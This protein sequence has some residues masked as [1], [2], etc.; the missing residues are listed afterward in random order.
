MGRQAATDWSRID[1]SLPTRVIAEQVGV[2]HQ[3]VAQRRRAAGMP[4]PPRD[5]AIAR[6]NAQSVLRAVIYLRR[7]RGAQ[8]ITQE[9][10]AR[11]SGVS[12]SRVQW[13]LW[14]LERR[15]LVEDRAESGRPDIW[16]TELGIAQAEVDK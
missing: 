5:S 9:E 14:R 2:R 16:P 13:H 7:S 10:I 11:L 12:L 4:L 15:R 1:W 3:C 8:R 6:A